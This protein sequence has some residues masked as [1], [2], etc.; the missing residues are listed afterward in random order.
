MD[1]FGRNRMDGMKFLG[2]CYDNPE[3]P[4][5]MRHL[6]NDIDIQNEHGAT[7]TMCY[8]LG[9]LTQLF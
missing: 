1:A 9:A 2:V 6:P 8:M 5:I 4:E 7:A 3:R